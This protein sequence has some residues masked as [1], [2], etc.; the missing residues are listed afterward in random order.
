MNAKVARPVGMAAI[1]AVGLSLSGCLKTDEF[2]VEP[3][4]T[5]K[6]M[7][8]TYEE[9]LDPSPDPVYRHFIYVTIGF[10]DGDGDIGLD[11][12]DTLAPFGQGEAHNF[13]TMCEFEKRVNG[14]WTGSDWSIPGRIKRISPSGQNPTLNGEIRWKLGPRESLGLPI[15]VGDTVRVSMWLE[16]RSLNRSNT[17]TSEGFVLQ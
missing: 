8:Q 7:E 5:F 14:T 11:E 1:L 3:I 9:I 4:L 17:V 12:G 10:T 2:P 15:A 6:S 13:N 16:D